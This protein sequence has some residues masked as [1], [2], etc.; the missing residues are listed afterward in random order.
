MIRSGARGV[1]KS[2]S[3]VG[4]DQ[5]ADSVNPDE[6]RGGAATSPGGGNCN[7]DEL[8]AGTPS[9]SPEPGTNVAEL[10]SG[11]GSAAIR[12]GLLAKLTMLPRFK[13]SVF[14][15][16]E[17]ALACTVMRLVLRLSADTPMP[18]LVLHGSAPP[19]PTVY[20]TDPIPPCALFGAVTLPLRSW[21]DHVCTLNLKRQKQGVQF[22]FLFTQV[23]GLFVCICTVARVV[24]NA[25]VRMSMSTC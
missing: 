22:F 23:F 13:A 1:A 5:A 12:T 6:S 11:L 14:Y 20:I 17:G 19:L 24:A 21:T 15:Q 7:G 9:R 16:P 3:T 25:A 10:G 4:K 18:A 2:G 8:L